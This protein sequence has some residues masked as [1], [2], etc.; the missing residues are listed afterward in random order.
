M[1]GTHG[2]AYATSS[3]G[4][5]SV[6]FRVVL[7]H[8]ARQSGKT[9]LA[10]LVVEHQGGTYTTLDDDLTLRAAL[11]DPITFLTNQQFPLAVR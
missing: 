9:T 4:G 1:R 3:R 8:G 7:L 10:R 11:D 6:L 2:P 5:R